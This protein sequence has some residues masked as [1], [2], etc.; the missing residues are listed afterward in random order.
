LHVKDRF[1]FDLLKKTLFSTR[2]MAFLFLAF[3]LAMAIGTFVESVYS[4]ETARIYIY[5]ATWFEVIM[6]FFVINFTGNIFR[7]NLLQWKKWPVLVLHLSW[8]LIIIGAGVTRYLGFEGMMPIREGE[9]EK[10]FYSDK[11]YLTAF[12]DG[13]I[14]GERLRK[15]LEYPILVTPEG[16]RSNLP[17]KDDFN[18]L[19]FTISYVDFIEG[20]KDGLIEDENGNEYLKIVEA[21]DGQ[22]H[23]HYLESGQIASIHNV[24]FSLNKETQGAINI[25]S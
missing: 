1:M 22:R 25:F 24:L 17:W 7:Y 18:N 11:T 19:P 12:M 10:V 13:E 4:T 6:V 2:L 21:G 16:K 14:G 23:E 8:I 3:A 15:T 20:A 5:N 9:S